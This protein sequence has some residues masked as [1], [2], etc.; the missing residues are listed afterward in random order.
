VKGGKVSLVATAPTVPHTAVTP[1]FDLCNYKPDILTQQHTT[2]HPR[3]LSN[4]TPS[5]CREII[6]RFVGA[7]RYV[8]AA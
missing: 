3:I 4:H 7:N 2:T 5:T 8:Q 1:L 6:G